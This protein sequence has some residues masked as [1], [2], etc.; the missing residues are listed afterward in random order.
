KSCSSEMFWATLYSTHRNILRINNDD[1]Q[2]EIG[3]LI[4]P[5]TSQEYAALVKGYIYIFPIS[6]L[7]MTV[8]FQRFPHI[9]RTSF[10]PNANML[11]GTFKSSELFQKSCLPF[12]SYPFDSTSGWEG[13]VVLKS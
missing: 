2:L 3:A 13:S 5:M 12:S 9:S 1:V 8:N 10:E 4:L 11:F 7:L 6:H